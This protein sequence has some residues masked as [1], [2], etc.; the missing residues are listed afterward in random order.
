MNNLLKRSSLNLFLPI[1][2]FFSCGACNSE[3]VEGLSAPS[4][5]AEPSGGGNMTVAGLPHAQ[6]KTFP[7]LDAYLAHLRKMGAQ[8]R[9]Y[10]KEVEPGKYQLMS[11]RGSNRREPQYFTREQLL[12]KYGFDH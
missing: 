6:G 7:N 9:P 8:D 10:Y 12:K 5:V 11:G 4:G 1:S 3:S 2:L